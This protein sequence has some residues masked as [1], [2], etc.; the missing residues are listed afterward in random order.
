MYSVMA[1][2]TFVDGKIVNAAVSLQVADVM[3]VLKH[4]SVRRHATRVQDSFSK[5]LAY[6]ILL[7][8]Y[9]TL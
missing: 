3:N 5:I 7:R 4:T 8:L 2:L 6:P 9:R 1:M